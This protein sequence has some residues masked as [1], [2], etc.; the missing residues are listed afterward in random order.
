MADNFRAWPNEYLD[1]NHTS[2]GIAGSLFGFNASQ[3]TVKNLGAGSAYLTFQSTVGSTA[4]FVLSSGESLTIREIGTQIAG[5][6]AA[7]SSTG[8]VLSV[9]AWG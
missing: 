1:G 4:D 7:S 2:T 8:N 9:G 6:G 3:V 5:F